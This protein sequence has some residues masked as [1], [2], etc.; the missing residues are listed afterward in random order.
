MIFKR[1]WYLEE[2][3]EFGLAPLLQMVAVES[4][5][6]LI[7]RP[8]I[9]F[10]HSANLLLAFSPQGV[11]TDSLICASLNRAGRSYELGSLRVRVKVQ[12]CD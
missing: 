10:K 12:E 2:D 6:L 3:F 9:L 11:G 8:I 1:F 5:T 7:I 4:N